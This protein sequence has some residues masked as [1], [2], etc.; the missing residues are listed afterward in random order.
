MVLRVEKGDGWELRLGDCLDPETGLASL[1]AV[2]HVITDPPYEDEAHT[3]QR[4]VK[5]SG[6]V[7]V[8]EPIPFETI[9]ARRSDVAM[10]MGAARRWVLAFCQA[11]VVGDWRSDFTTAGLVFKRSCVWIKPDGLPQLNGDRPGMGYESIVVCHAKGRSRWNGGG[12]HGVYTFN[13]GSGG[14]PNVHPTQKPLLLMEQLLRDFTDPG[15][16]V[17]DPFSG[18]GTTG[19]A[20][21]R[22]G[23]RFIGWERDEKYYEA[24]LKRLRNAKPQGDLFTPGIVGKPQ[25]LPGLT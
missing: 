17:A 22:L 18:S 25:A 19:V 20:C 3:K 7:T 14:M 13:K 9:T 8:V 5:R 15:E 4:R 21:I 12:K 23:R 24:A 1:G 2:D 10:A 11:E 6:G 16:L